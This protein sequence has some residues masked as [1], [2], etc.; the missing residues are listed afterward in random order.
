MRRVSDEESRVDCRIGT[1]G[2]RLH[3]RSSSRLYLLRLLSLSL[4]LLLLRLLWLWLRGALPRSRPWSTCPR[5]SRILLED[6]LDPFIMRPIVNVCDPGRLHIGPV[7]PPSREQSGRQVLKG[8]RAVT[9][10]SSDGQGLHAMPE[11]Q[12][13]NLPV[14][15]DG[16]G[17]RVVDKEVVNG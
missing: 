12:C 6:P 4:S 13:D 16:N 8:G 2:G 14:G 11:C 7:H 10:A 5:D 3:S 1:G 9:K 17:Q 15:W